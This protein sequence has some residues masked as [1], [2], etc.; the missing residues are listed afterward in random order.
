MLADRTV[1]PRD[2]LARA[3]HGGS[4]AANNRGGNMK[5]TAAALLLST[6]CGA[7]S[8]AAAKGRAGTGTTPCD[9]YQLSIQATHCKVKVLI[10]GVANEV[11]SLDATHGG[12]V[13]GPLHERDLKPNNTIT[14]QLEAT[15]AETTVSLNVLGVT[16]ERQIVST[17]EP[18]NV[19]AL[20]L[21]AKQIAASKSKRFSARFAASFRKAKPRAKVE[22]VGEAEAKEY[23]RYLAGLLRSRQREKL[24]D[25]L[26]P[27][28]LQS[29]QAK[30][31]S[32]AEVREKVLG[33]M[34]GLL[35]D[36]VFLA[37]KGAPIEV[38]TMVS[39]SRATYEL[40]VRDGN[41]LLQF[42]E[43]G[44]PEKKPRDIIV[45]IEKVGGKIQIVEFGIQ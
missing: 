27:F 34:P 43:R 12:A 2:R 40:R 29:P 13:S 23:A 22:L 21:D 17:N 18:G 32:A 7:N 26:L 19:L 38:K 30:G 10:N 5:T 9:F 20:D 37:D 8:L 35:D 4:G 15:D 31:L 25:E 1:V 3:V 28:A 16:S 14:L 44:S 33:E 24:A 11:L 41:G 42:H 36:K 39:E 45:I 6:L